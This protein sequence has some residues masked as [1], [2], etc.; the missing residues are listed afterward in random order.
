MNLPSGPLISSSIPARVFTLFP[1]LPLELCLMIWRTALSYQRAITANCNGPT[2]LHNGK[3]L[4]ETV[5]PVSASTVLSAVSQEAREALHVQ[6]QLHWTRHRKATIYCS[7]ECDILW[8]SASGH[9]SDVSSEIVFSLEDIRSS[10]TLVR[11][12][13]LAFNLDLWNFLMHVPA[14]LFDT[15]A[16]YGVEEL[17]IV[18][19]ICGA[20]RSGSVLFNE[21]HATPPAILPPAMLSDLSAALKSPYTWEMLNQGFMARIH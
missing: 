3:L 17:L 5:R 13:K 8:L 21:P 18:V 12:P 15:I 10:G 11:L 7:G 14:R 16:K 20:F 19:G 1:K 4:P 9:R 6:Q 2:Y